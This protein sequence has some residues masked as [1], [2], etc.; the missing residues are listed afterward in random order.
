VVAS[1]AVAASASTP[2][3]EDMLRN[4]LSYEG[5]GQY[6][7]AYDLLAPGQKKLISRDKFI[8]C[9]GTR[10]ESAGS[11]SSFTVAS[12]KK[13]DQYRDPVHVTGVTQKPIVALTIKW[14]IKNDNGGKDSETSTWHAV[15]AS[16]RWTWM[17]KNSDVADLHA[18]RCPH[19]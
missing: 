7:R 4:V 9:W 18:G 3:P 12:F 15:W 6:G 10:F 1:S 5:L 2:K 11:F 14:T 17:L 16:G 8:D 13:V 19:A